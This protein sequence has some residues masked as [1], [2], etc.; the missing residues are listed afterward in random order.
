[1]KRNAAPLLLLIAL[2][3]LAS[4]ALRAQTPKFGWV[5]SQKLIEGF[6]E[7]QKAQK[8]LDAKLKLWK[9]SLEA[10][11][12]AFQA[13]VQTYQRQESNMN[14]PAKKAR[15]QE[16]VALQKDLQDY[17]QAK[18][19]EAAAYRAELFQPITERIMKAIEDISKEE[20]LTFMFN[21]S[22][23][24]SPIVLYAEPKI[25]YTNRVLDR[26]IRGN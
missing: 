16:L 8:A 1:V 3:I 9:D 19:S 7:A 2:V 15:Q 13:E 26:L 23:D 21:K 24:A 10:K 25:D 14:E 11:G 17:E 5:D 6:P 12:Q 20:K 22:Q 4:P 18:S